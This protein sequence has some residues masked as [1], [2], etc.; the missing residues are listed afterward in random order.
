VSAAAR[1]LP[2]S[3]AVQLKAA[4]YASAHLQHRSETSTDGLSTSSFRFS[5]AFSAFAVCISAAAD[6]KKPLFD[7]DV[8]APAAFCFFRYRQTN[9]VESRPFPPN[10][11]KRRRLTP[12]CF[13]KA[14]RSSRYPSLRRTRVTL[15]V[16]AFRTQSAPRDGGGGG[17]RRRRRRRRCEARRLPG[18]T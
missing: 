2:P 10:N 1:T 12:Y 9:E 3:S 8:C 5:S 14:Q 11:S 18:G 13:R 7:C 4:L 16:V 17:R 6:G 15:C